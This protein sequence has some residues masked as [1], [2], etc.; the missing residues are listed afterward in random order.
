MSYDAFA[1]NL[2]FAGIKHARWA[3]L[4]VVLLAGSALG[5]TTT[6]SSTDGATPLALSPGAPAGSY[7]L[8]DIE[9]INPAN[10]HLNIRIPLV[11]AG[12]RGG[13]QATLMLAMDLQP[14]RI[15]HRHTIN[16]KTGVETDTYSPTANRWGGITPGYGPGVLQGRSSAVS[17]YRKPFFIPPPYMSTQPASVKCRCIP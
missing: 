4:G 14:W 5:Q 9:V 2:I 7:P 12:G 8:S 6:T 11:H 17:P 3:T 15:T 10:G 1:I 16:P 13:A